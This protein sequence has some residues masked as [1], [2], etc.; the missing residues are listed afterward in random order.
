MINPDKLIKFLN[1]NLSFIF[2]E[3]VSIVQQ[4]EQWFL[5]GINYRNIYSFW[6]KSVDDIK[7]DFSNGLF[8]NDE[9]STL[10]FFLSNYYEHFKSNNSSL[11]DPYNRI[12]FK[13]SFFYDMGYNR[14]YPFVDSIL[15]N[16][17][18]R[19]GFNF[20]SGK[21]LFIT[22]DVDLLNLPKKKDFLRL[23]YYMLKDFKPIQILQVI[24]Y[25]LLWFNPYNLNFLYIIHELTG[26]FGD[27]LFL[28][29]KQPFVS[30]GYDFEELDNI[31]KVI[32]NHPKHGVGIHYNDD[33]LSQGI[34]L[35]KLEK[36]FEI[37]IRA[38]RAHYL[39][40]NP[41]TSLDILSKSGL[42]IDSTLGYNDM[43]GYRNGTSHPF[44]PWDWTN[45][46][47]SNVL[48]V[49]LIV[50][51]GTLR[52]SMKLGLRRAYK[53]LKDLIDE[54]EI[55]HGNFTILWH[56]SSVIGDGWLSWSFLYIMIIIYAKK[57]GFK[58][59][60]LEDLIPTLN[61]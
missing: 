31:K 27:F 16:I 8:S 13:D 17:A 37:N 55:N 12:T 34:N 20:R 42:S 18:K 58:S 44:Y 48:E 9:I 1:I 19:H 45:D 33:Y 50:M 21:K 59:S 53:R 26:T 30:G 39:L 43:I 49:P 47:V 5:N 41:A 32:L 25:K 7:K 46:R 2:K 6:E 52:F 38:G 23:I 57:K 29:Q 11:D 36:K 22:H 15:I 14:T 24:I 35:D 61:K 51:D 54:I 4:E 3:D 28:T 40:F 56:N 60:K 10:A